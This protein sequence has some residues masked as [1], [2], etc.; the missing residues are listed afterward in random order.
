MGGECFLVSKEG[1]IATVTINRP[2]Q[3]NA[4]TRAMWARLPDM[5][6]DFAADSD[7]RVVIIRGAGEEAFASGQDIREFQTM[8]TPEE[9]KHHSDVVED[10]WRRIYQVE[11][12]VIAMVHG[13]AMGGAFGLLAMCD[14]R[15]SAE[16]G[17]FAVPAGRLG[18]VYPEIL[19]RRIISLIGPANT[20][21]LLIT[22]RRYSA[23]EAHAMGFVNRVLPKDKLET[24]VRDLAVKIVS[25]A[26]L[27]VKNSKRMVNLIEENTLGLEDRVRADD[28]R[29]E[30]FNSEDF[31]EGVRA[32]IEKRTPNFKG[33]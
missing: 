8:K 31:K 24:Y 5:L 18:V 26:P 21:E 16:D 19:T 6:E 13:F 22:A 20:K 3:R 4:L 29:H 9:W 1:G 33:I 27:S 15:Y 28:L 30:G 32:F 23:E 2:E 17:V 14:L 12:P 7:I 10:A 25:N 11:M